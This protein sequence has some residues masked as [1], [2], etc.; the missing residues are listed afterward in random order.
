MNNFSYELLFNYTGVKT[1]KK[2]QP[3]SATASSTTLP[4]PHVSPPSK[5]HQKT[6]NVTELA[7]ALNQ[8]Q[9][10]ISHNLK[11]LL[12]CR[13]IFLETQGKNHIYSLNHETL[14]P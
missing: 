2:S 6:M 5:T 13:L 3:P 10:M 1:R 9:S 8:E 14:T 11:P 4:I 7:Q 12:D